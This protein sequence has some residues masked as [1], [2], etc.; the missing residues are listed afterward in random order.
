MSSLILQT[1]QSIV[2]HLK[3]SIDDLSVESFPEKPSRY[4]LRHAKGAALVIYQGSRYSDDANMFNERTMTWVV[5]LLMRHL[6]SHEGAYA[7][8]ESIIQSLVGFK[9]TG[10]PNPLLINKDQFIREDDGVWQYDLVFSCRRPHLKGHP[11]RGVR[12]A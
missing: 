10:S 5:T 6:K 7:Y 2:E 1:E 11:C 12:N 8:I 3:A 9:P 4:R